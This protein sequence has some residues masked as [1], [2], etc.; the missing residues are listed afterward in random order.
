MYN[1]KKF[2]KKW[3]LQDGIFIGNWNKLIWE[4]QKKTLNMDQNIW[5]NPPENSWVL[6]AS[7]FPKITALGNS[8]SPTLLTPSTFSLPKSPIR[9]QKGGRKMNKLGYIKTA[10]KRPNAIISIT[11]PN[12]G[13][14][15]KVSLFLLNNHVSSRLLGVQGV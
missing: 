9:A 6:Q 13:Q 4:I 8:R 3:N 11:R 15:T 1:R 7:W 12:Y 14:C 5:T 2:K 10:K